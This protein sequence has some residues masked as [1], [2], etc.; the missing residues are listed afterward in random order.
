LAG[1]AHGDLKR[2][3][4]LYRKKLP[5]IADGRNILA[6]LD[7]FA[8]RR[9]AL[10]ALATFVLVLLLGVLQVREAY[11]RHI[12]EFTQRNSEL[13]E[14]RRERKELELRS[15]QAQATILALSRDNE[16]LRGSLAAVLEERNEI[17]K[18]L[19]AKG[20]ET[21]ELSASIAALHAEN[22]ELQATI[23]QQEN[24]SAAM[25]SV[26]I[27]INRDIADLKSAREKERVDADNDRA[28][29]LATAVE[30]DTLIEE[31]IKLTAT[32]ARYTLASHPCDGSIFKHRY[33]CHL[34]SD[35]A[36]ERPK[37]EPIGPI[38]RPFDSGVVCS[39]P[40]R[41]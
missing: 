24:A 35:S 39:A 8:E 20:R 1:D 12:H 3:L 33:D 30:R 41:K 16:K 2:D 38:C 19:G 14:A 10:L 26:L 28:A 6:H 7:A 34:A 40:R 17:A 32:R 31:N 25:R 23:A 36:G 21:A 13:A 11:L 18:M 37:A 29:C 9:R 22:E 27:E 5:T 4:E 15:S